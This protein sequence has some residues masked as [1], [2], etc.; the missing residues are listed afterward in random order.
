[1]KKVIS[2]SLWGDDPKYTMGAIENASLSKIIYPDWVCRFYIGKSVPLHIVEHLSKF[3]NTE[4]VKM[5]EEGDWRG[6]FWR[7]WIASDESVDIAIVRDCDSRVWLRERTA[8]K[9]WLASDKDFHIIKD[10]PYHST[11]ILGGMWGVRNGLLKDMR[12]LCDNYDQG[13]FWQVDQNFL[14]EVVYPI[15]K[16][17]SI[18]HSFS[19][20]QPL[21]QNR[22]SNHFIGQVYDGC[23][24]I[25]DG[26]EYFQDFIRRQIDA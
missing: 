26:E 22:D 12:L 23:G 2:F 14:S 8:V 24:R 1:M 5:N 19:G 11:P 9:E 7:F 16:G 17:N 10:H 13:N 6:M 15:V 25:F 21:P 18:T 3:N 4:I 20:A